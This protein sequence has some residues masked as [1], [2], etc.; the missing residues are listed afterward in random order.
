MRPMEEDVEYLATL[1]AMSAAGESQLNELA[2]VSRDYALV[3]AKTA[4]KRRLLKACD[5]DDV[6]QKAVMR[7]LASLG[8]WD[9][10]RGGWKNYVAVIAWSVIGDERRGYAKD[11]DIKAA[12]RELN[13]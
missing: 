7:A 1:A 4:V 6:A 11:A 8:K 5:V 2:K 12:I 13:E 9:V 3:I 10:G